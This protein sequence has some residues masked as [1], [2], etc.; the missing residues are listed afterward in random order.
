LAEGIMQSEAMSQDPVYFKDVLRVTL[1]SMIEDFVSGQ[2][3]SMYTPVNMLLN[4]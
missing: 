1:G 2:T 4:D 3:E